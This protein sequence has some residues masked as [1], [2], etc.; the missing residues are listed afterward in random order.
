MVLWQGHQ[1][2]HD[3]RGNDDD[4][5]DSNDNNYNNNNNNAVAL[6]AFTERCS[7]RLC[8]TA[9]NATMPFS[10]ETERCIHRRLHHRSHPGV[11][12][13]AAL[14]PSSSSIR[15]NTIVDHL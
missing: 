13:W 7:D 8:S 10:N 9:L 11:Q 15:F 3:P 1:H 14:M 6:N 5:D 4:D 2:H 12:T